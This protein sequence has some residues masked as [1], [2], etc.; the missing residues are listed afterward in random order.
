MIEDGGLGLCPRFSFVIGVA[1]VPRC[2]R[3]GAKDE[4]LP[5]KNQDFPS[6]AGFVPHLH[7][8]TAKVRKI[9]RNKSNFMYCTNYPL[10]CTIHQ[11][12]GIDCL[13]RVITVRSRKTDIGR[14]GTIRMQ[15]STSVK[16][17][18]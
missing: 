12:L 3:K 17:T 6:L 14:L 10:F 16:G 4:E 1:F 13:F 11:I 2:D 15:S 7:D 18:F 8:G 9:K 5:D